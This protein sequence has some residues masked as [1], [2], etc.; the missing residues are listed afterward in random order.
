MHSSSQKH[1]SF[2]HSMDLGKCVLRGEIRSDVDSLHDVGATCWSC[3]I[4]SLAW[5]N[6]PVENEPCRVP[7]RSARHTNPS[8]DGCSAKSYLTTTT[9][10][11]ASFSGAAA[12]R[13][14]FT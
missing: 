14:G 13:P 1:N 5:S 11:A 8:C 4:A 10:S 6:R 7:L 3:R 2:C 12:G 9:K